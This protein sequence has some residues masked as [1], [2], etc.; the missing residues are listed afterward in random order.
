MHLRKAMFSMCLN[1]AKNSMIPRPHCTY[2]HMYI[3]TYV[4]AYQD[5]GQDLGLANVLVQTST[6]RLDYA[7]LALAFRAGAGMLVWQSHT[8]LELATWVG[9]SILGWHWQTGLA[10]VC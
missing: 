10:L 4:R 8:G 1:I 9:T 7:E 6:S 2:A 3:F 5:L